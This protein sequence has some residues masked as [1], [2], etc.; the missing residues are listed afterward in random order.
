MYTATE[1][2]IGVLTVVCNLI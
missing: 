2:H 1:D